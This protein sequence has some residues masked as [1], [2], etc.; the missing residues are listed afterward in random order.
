MGKLD[1]QYT[2]SPFYGVL[3]MTAF[4]RTQGKNLNPKRVRCLLRTMGLEAI[5][6]KTKLSQPSDNSRR[7]PYLLRG[8]AIEG[9]NQVWSA[10]ITYIRCRIPLV[11]TEGEFKN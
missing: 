4:P 7:Y 2:Q 11:L 6:P 5:Y 3:R 8:L 10:D 1:E 9:S